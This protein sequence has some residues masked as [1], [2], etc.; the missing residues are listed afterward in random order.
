MRYGEGGA[1]I[2]FGEERRPVFG[3]QGQKRQSRRRFPPASARWAS[4]SVVGGD[5]YTPF[6]RSDMS[7]LLT[8]R[9]DFWGGTNHLTPLFYDT[10]Q[11]VPA[12]GTARALGALAIIDQTLAASLLRYRAV[13]TGRSEPR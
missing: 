3:P 2:T 1:L 4:L 10:E 6:R 13:C 11:S 12:R 9:T 7:R 8:K 5:V